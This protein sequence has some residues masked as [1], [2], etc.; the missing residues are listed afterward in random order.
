MALS[1]FYSFSDNTLSLMF[2]GNSINSLLSEGKFIRHTT[3]ATK[4]RCDRDSSKECLFLYPFLENFECKSVLNWQR[5]YGR[6]GD[7]GGLSLRRQEKQ[8]TN[9]KCVRR[10]RACCVPKPMCGTLHCRPMWEYYSRCHFQGRKSLSISGGCVRHHQ[11]CLPKIIR[12][13][14]HGVTTMIKC[15]F[16]RETH[17]RRQHDEIFLP[18]VELNLFRLKL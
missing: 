12:K 2:P 16:V 5:I 3:K 15:K 11:V 8:V 9:I 18:T 7:L 1:N 14:N 6:D 17:E 13:C 4:K 10:S